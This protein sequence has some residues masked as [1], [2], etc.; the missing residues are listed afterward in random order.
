[1]KILIV[2]DEIKTLNGIEFLINQM[3]KDW[4]IV[5]K[6]KNGEEGIRLALEEEPDVIISDIRMNGMTGLEMIREL[7]KRRF[8]GKYIILSG[9]AEF[10][11]ARE[12]MLL[13]SIDYLLKPVTGDNLRQVLEKAETIIKD[14]ATKINVG[15]LT[16][17]QLLERALYMP[18]FESSK[19]YQEFKNR[20]AGHNKIYLLLVK[21]E[22]RLVQADYEHLSKIA[23]EF[24]K[25]KEFYI[26]REEG[27]KEIYIL[28]LSTEDEILEKLDG[29]IMYYRAK[30]NP[31][32]V[33]I[34]Q[35]MKDIKDI[36]LIRQQLLDDCHWNLS[37]KQDIVINKKRIEDICV[38]HFTYPSELETQI[39][40]GISEGRIEFVEECLNK[41]LEYLNK[42]TYSY[43]DIREAMICLTA[44]ILYGIRKE[45]Y[46]L[47]E[48]ISNLNILEWV[49]EILFIEHYP[50]IVINIIRQYNHYTENLKSGTHP[51]I[52][53]VLKIIDEEYYD[54]LPQDEIAKRMNV[55]PEYLSSL[56]M[57]EL[58]IKFTTYKTQKRIEVAKRLLREGN[59]K[60]YEIAEESGY[61]DVRYFTKVFKKYTG[62]SPG[63]YVRTLFEK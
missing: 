18:Q 11:Y 6:A 41:F 53:K 36:Q 29:M 63:E 52:T 20:L 25:D 54:E 17:F 57:K 39:V 14:E 47:Y 48:N 15:E 5:G 51:I 1:M 26:Y 23:S 60:I 30:I 3:K 2:E 33:F 16:N 34:G 45:S 24:I 27:H 40:H 31:Y 21:G 56:F 46:G 10:Q 50:Q 58:G 7:H 4:F 61:T 44:A 38:Q 12:A 59:K 22:N 49:K 43:T 62:V 55:T 32:V 42:K 13:G 8:S 35:E 19:F 37:L 9:Y 28:V